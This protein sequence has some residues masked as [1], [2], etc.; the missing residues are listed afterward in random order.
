MGCSI[1]WYQMV[2]EAMSDGAVN[3]GVPRAVSYKLIA[4]SMEGAAKMVLETGEA[5]GVV[6]CVYGKNLKLNIK[7]HFKRFHCYHW[8]IFHEKIA[9]SFLVECLVNRP[10]S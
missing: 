10:V 1:A 7:R 6:S 5:P 8:V 9:R 4:K 2:I 3:N